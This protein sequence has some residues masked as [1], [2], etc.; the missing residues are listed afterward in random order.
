MRPRSDDPSCCPDPAARGARAGT[1]ELASLHRAPSAL[2]GAVVAVVCRDT[3]DVDLTP[4]QRLSHF[5]ASPLLS[6]G[7]YSDVEAGL[8]DRRPDAAGQGQGQE[9]GQGQGKGQWR[10]F[11]SSVVIAGSQSAPITGW[12]PSSGRAGMIL[13]DVEVARSLFGLDPTP[14]HDRFV[15]ARRVLAPAWHGLLDDLLAAPADAAVL[16]ALERHL[17]GPWRALRKQDSA[18]GALMRI[19]RDWVDRLGWQAH[20]W[21]L[22]HGQRQVERRIK[23]WTGRSLRSWQA[24]VQTEGLFE[25]ARGRHDVGDAFDWA[26]LA[27]DEGFADQAHMTRATR[28]ITG[29]SPADF[30]RRFRDDESFWLYRLWV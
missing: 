10:A 17:G 27:Q 3:S 12:T 30:A 6:L 28:R 24:L 16:T 22:T 2:A 19:G 29:F 4:A 14:I 23:T 20:Q 18:S 21:R 8:V 26:A 5:P 9:Q 25:A 7:W 13:F 15:D 11:E 1:R